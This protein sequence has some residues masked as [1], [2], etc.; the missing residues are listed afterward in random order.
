MFTACNCR[1]S[2]PHNKD[3]QLKIMQEIKDQPEC[4]F[5]ESEIKGKYLCYYLRLRTLPGLASKKAHTTVLP[6]IGITFGCEFCS[7]VAVKRCYENTRRTF[8]E[9]QEEKKEFAEN[10]A[11]CRKYRSRRQRVRAVIDYS[12]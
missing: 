2:S 4:K 3:V 12:G 9:S 7:S 8:L 5:S 1:S 10:Q 6:K 11:K